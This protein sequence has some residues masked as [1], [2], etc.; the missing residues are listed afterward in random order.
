MTDAR[1]RP[2]PTKVCA[3]VV[4]GRGSRRVRPRRRI[5]HRD[6]KPANILIDDQGRPR[7]ADFGLA[8]RDDDRA[9]HA[10]ML[11]G[12]P[13]YM[14]PEQV[15]RDAAGLD[16][17]IDVLALGV[18]LYELLGKQRPFQAKNR[19]TLFARILE[20]RPTPL[21][22]V[23]RQVPAELEPHLSSMSGGRSGERYPSASALAVDIRH[24]LDRRRRLRRGMQLAAAIVL[25]STMGFGIW[26]YQE[27][28]QTVGSG[29][30][31]R[32]PRDGGGP[33]G[34]IGR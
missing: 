21:R 34:P 15:R 9:M 25:V 19:E 7:V 27:L 33:P 5:V 11:V 1:Q 6:L 20:A 12:S 3:I 30:C 8:L 2:A 16:G 31:I 4:A 18:I 23:D 17:R 32:R 24:W 10:G 13:A 14:S 28:L 22:R 26:A 29:R